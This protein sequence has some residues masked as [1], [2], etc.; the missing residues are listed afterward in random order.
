MVYLSACVGQVRLWFFFRSVLRPEIDNEA[1]YSARREAPPLFCDTTCL[2]DTA[3]APEQPSETTRETGTTDSVRR[4]GLPRTHAVL[5]RPESRTKLCT[6]RQLSV[7]PTVR[8]GTGH[9]SGL[10]HRHQGRM[11]QFPGA[12]CR[13]ASPAT[14]PRRT[15]PY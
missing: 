3:M 2:E 9:L 7:V 1:D 4:R 15:T 14:G 12:F 10:L 5:G 6:W 8:R 13:Q 11:H